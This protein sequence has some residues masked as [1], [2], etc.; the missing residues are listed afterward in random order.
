MTGYENVTPKWNSSMNVDILNVWTGNGR[1]WLQLKK[2]ANNS[3]CTICGV[4]S[5]M[6]QYIVEKKKLV[7]EGLAVHSQWSLESG[8]MQP[9]V[10]NLMLIDYGKHDDPLHVAK[11]RFHGTVEDSERKPNEDRPLQ[12]ASPR[13][14]STRDETCIEFLSVSFQHSLENRKDCFFLSALVGLPHDYQRLSE[15][16]VAHIPSVLLKENMSHMTQ[17]T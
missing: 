8:R 3:G 15:T 11:I 17:G 14:M 2:D 16:P 10:V 6:V 5:R 1:Q 7:E 13:G 12:N 4:L 9:T